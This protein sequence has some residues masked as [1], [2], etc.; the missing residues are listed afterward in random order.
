MLVEQDEVAII[1]GILKGNKG[2]YEKLVKEYQKK[3]FYTV[4]RMVNTQEDA[5]DLVQETFLQAYKQLAKFNRQASFY[6]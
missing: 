6:T 5:L 4:Y 1:D 3:V 2:L